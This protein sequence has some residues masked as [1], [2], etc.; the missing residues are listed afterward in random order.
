MTAISC[1]RPKERRSR[2]R[3]GS[4]R[5]SALEKRGEDADVAE[6]HGER[7]RP[8]PSRRAATASA[9]ASASAATRSV[10]A[11]I[12]VAGLQ[13][14]RRARVVAAEDQAFIG[15]AL[16]A[17]AAPQV[18]EAD[19]DGEIGPQ[20]QPLAGAPFGDEHSSADVLAGGLQERVGG[21]QH[22][23]LDPARA[24]AL[25]ESAEV[26]S[27]RRRRPWASSVS[28]LGAAGRAQDPSPSPSPQGGG[29]GASPPPLWGRAREGA[30]LHRGSAL[31]RPSAA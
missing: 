28:R 1:G 26:G 27:R 12:L 18:L 13:P 9:S 21:M 6:A 29:A 20:R 8:R 23:Q 19:G 4:G 17:R 5:P 25:V 11:D 15:V 7:R 14:L 22:G 3:H 16:G 10:A 24:G 31:S 2:R 30:P